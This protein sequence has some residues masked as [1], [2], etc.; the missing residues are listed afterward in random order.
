MRNT[1]FKMSSTA[2]FGLVML[3]WRCRQRAR[4]VMTQDT[5]TKN[6]CGM[7]DLYVEEASAFELHLLSHPMR[8]CCQMSQW[9]DSWQLLLITYYHEGPLLLVYL[10]VRGLTMHAMN[11]PHSVMNNMPSHKY[12]NLLSQ[13]HRRNLSCSSNLWRSHK[14]H[15]LSRLHISPPCSL[16]SRMCKRI[17]VRYECGHIYEIGTMSC[18][19]NGRE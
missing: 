18:R 10:R 7:I 9:Y 15:I 19:R 11:R 13:K 12:P 6:F 17:F 16:S 8:A 4:S 1:K 3:L 2:I 5:S 14:K